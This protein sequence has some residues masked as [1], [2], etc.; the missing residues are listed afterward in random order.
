MIK[1]YLIVFYLTTIAIWPVTLTLIGL[2]AGVSLNAKCRGPGLFPI[3]PFM[4]VAVAVWQ[5]E[6]FT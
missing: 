4:L 5:C 6:R 2:S 3:I 1:D